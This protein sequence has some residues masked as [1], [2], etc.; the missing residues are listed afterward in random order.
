MALSIEVGRGVATS[1][2]SM[3]TSRRGHSTVCPLAE[4][5][6]V[7]GLRQLISIVPL[8]LSSPIMR[9]EYLVLRDY[10]GLLLTGHYFIHTTYEE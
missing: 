4:I 10:R 1:V 6:S 5:Y 3:V 7:G 2:R 8:G 9:E